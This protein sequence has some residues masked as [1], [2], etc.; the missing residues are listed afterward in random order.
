MDVLVIMPPEEESTVTV[1]VSDVLGI[2]VCQ[3]YK[4]N[5]KQKFCQFYCCRVSRDDFNKT[6]FPK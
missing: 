2:K 3:D 5:K 1:A 4:E 6:F